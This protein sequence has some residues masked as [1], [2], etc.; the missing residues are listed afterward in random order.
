MM[1][2]LRKNLQG[3]G[4]IE[5]FSGSSIQPM[6]DGIQFALS[7]ARQVGAFWQILAKQPIGVLGCPPLPRAVGIGKKYLD[8][9]SLCQALVFGHLF[10][11]I[12]GQGLAQR[13]RHMLKLSDNP[14]SSTPRI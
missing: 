5:T 6:G 11:P 7:I 9:E 1:T 8:G 4:P 12:I 14:L 13:S 2:Q 3:R 10:S